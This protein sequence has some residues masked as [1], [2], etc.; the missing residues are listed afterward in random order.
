MDTESARRLGAGPLTIGR[1]VAVT[2]AASLVVGLLVGPMIA[3][4]RATGA[5]PS[6]T[7]PEHTVTVTGTGEVSV[8]PDVADVIIGVTVQKPTVKEAQSSAATSMTAAIAAVK[9]DGVADKD[10][11]TVDVSLNP[12][13]DYGSGGSIPRL[14]GQSFSNTVKVT[15]HDLTK[16]GSIIDD[17][18]AAGATTVEGVSFRLNDPKS[19]EAQARQL[20]MTD[21]RS[22]AD[23]LASAS[24]VQVKGV[25]SIA[26]VTA[27]SP[28]MYASGALDKAAVAAST[29]IQTGTTDTQ[30]Q[31]T[32]SYLI[33]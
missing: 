8:A 11:V 1:V 23:A 33:G 17:S 13:Y 9:K 32:V 19:V 21:A 20:A 18:I 30:I 12:V 10:I 7:T 6:T 16:L 5:D 26:E 27:S 15:V 29:P 24:G 3:N 2:A 25:A 31:V 28:I 4:Y 22:K 14:V